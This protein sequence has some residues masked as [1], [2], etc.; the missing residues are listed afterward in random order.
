MNTPWREIALRFRVWA[1]FEIWPIYN[2]A[3]QRSIFSILAL[4]WQNRNYSNSA[5]ITKTKQKTMY[6]HA[7]DQSGQ[8]WDKS[9]NLKKSTCR[10]LLSYKECCAVKLPASC[11]SK[12]VSYGQNW[13]YCLRS[14]SS[15]ISAYFCDNVF[16][17]KLFLQ[18]S[19]SCV[20]IWPIMADSSNNFIFSV[21]SFYN[22]IIGNCHG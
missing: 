19:V 22:Y 18:L 10:T 21:F 8:I 11:P 7:N 17:A 14:L 3:G 15:C 1:M 16:M 12:S 13:S 9:E 20:F 4:F 5:Q 6:Y 2:T